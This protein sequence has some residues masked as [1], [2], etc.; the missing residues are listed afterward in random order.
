MK[1]RY[2]KINKSHLSLGQ[3][4]A[5]VSSCA[6]DSKETVAAVADLIATGR[7]SVR[8]NGVSKKLRLAQA[9]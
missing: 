2:S 6:R 8:D 9:M 7:V 3:L 1:N 5:I 4:V